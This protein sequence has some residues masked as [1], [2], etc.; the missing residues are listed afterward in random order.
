VDLEQI[1]QIARTLFGALALAAV[2]LVPLLV[3]VTVV[4]RVRDWAAG[5]EGARRPAGRAFR[6]LRS[7]LHGSDAGPDDGAT[8]AAPR[9]PPTPQEGRFIRLALES[10]DLTEEQVERCCRFQAEKRERGSLIPL[11]DCAVLADLMEQPV[12]ERL[13]DEAGELDAES[14]GDY[15]LLRKIGEG[16]MGTVW[17]ANA[18]DGQAV[19]L[20][21]LSPDRARERPQLTRF[22]REAQAA[23]KLR[24]EHLV[25][26][27]ELGED[28][29]RYFLAMEYVPG[30]SVRDVLERH[31]QLPTRDTTRIIAQV[32][33][34]LDYAHASGVVHRDVK[35]GNIMLAADGAARL[36]DLGLARYL[37]PDLTALTRS[38]TGMGTPAYIA[39]EQIRGAK[40]ADARS[41][42]YSLGATW[43]HM[44]TGRPPFVAATGFDVLQKHLSEPLVPPRDV[45]PDVPEAVSEFVES[46]MAKEPDERVQTA[47]EVGRFIREHAAARQ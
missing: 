12:A 13:Q 38:E 46:M 26:G 20:K 32:A 8:G 1:L 27:I 23:V 4:N 10:G 15:V 6:R 39:P 42:I 11:W 28:R 43:Y 3:V 22:M 47:G 31:G 9:R 36:A 30:G 37:E 21:V 34:A 40:R 7:L 25:R 35:P 33:D 18:P 19:A 29:G 16:A 44:L 14:V 2:V 45:R 17:L 24:H 5:S 41:D